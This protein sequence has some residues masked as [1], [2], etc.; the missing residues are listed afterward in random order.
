MVPQLVLSPPPGSSIPAPRAR[1]APPRP[2]AGTHCAICLLRAGAD[3]GWDF[4]FSLFAAPS[5]AAPR[6]Q[7]HFSRRAQSIRC[8][9]GA[10]AARFPRTPM[11]QILLPLTPSCYVPPPSAALSCGRLL[12]PPRFFSL[13]SFPLVLVLLVYLPHSSPSAA[14]GM[15][16]WGGGDIA[17]E[18]DK[19]GRGRGEANG[20]DFAVV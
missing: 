19:L 9:C 17:E 15:R 8:G 13:K 16:A 3:P 7:T 4:S 2:A 6:P 1:I 18:A 11:A 14:R 10:A 12:C 5:L 20:R